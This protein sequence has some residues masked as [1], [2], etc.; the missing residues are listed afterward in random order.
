[1]VRFR[2]VQTAMGFAGFV[3]TQRGL[4]AVQ[5]PQKN[6]SAAVAGVRRAYPNAVEDANLLPNLARGL[7]RFFA[8]E[9][10]DF[11]VPLD[12]TDYSD[13]ETDVWQACR[14]VKYG[15][16]C[17]YKGLADRLGRPGGARAVGM[18]M[19]HNPCP[20]VVPCHRVVRSDGSLGGYSGPGGIGFKQRL[21]EMEAAVAHA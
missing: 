15:E 3:A 16:T 5:L 14:G 18:A 8:G 9:P 11:D 6:R 2:I 4:R 1:M 13:F 10:V 17:S 7:L 19:A 12:W 21:L 20:I